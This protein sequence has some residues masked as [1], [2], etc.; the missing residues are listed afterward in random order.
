MMLSL[1]L[2]IVLLLFPAIS[3]SRP[4]IA[5]AAPQPLN[6]SIDVS[7]PHRSAYFSPAALLPA[8]T[9]AHSATALANGDIMV[10]GGYGKLFAK[11]PVATNLIRLFDHHNLSWRIAAGKLNFGR[12]EHAAIRLPDNSVL[13]VGGRGQDGNP[14]RSIELFNPSDETCTLIG[15]MAIARLRPCLNLISPAP[16]QP[17]HFQVL[18]TGNSRR[19]ELIEPDPNRPDAYTIRPTRSQSLANHTDHTTVTLKDGRVLI[20]A[21]RSNAIEIYDPADESFH[22][23][24]SRLPAAL[25]DQAAALLYDSR[26]FIAG[27]QFIYNNT[28]TNRTWLFDPLADTLT[29]GPVLKPTSQTQ[30]QPGAADLAA[31]D[32][33]EYDLTR[34]GRYILLCGGENDPGKGNSPDIVLDSAWV[35]D[36]QRGIFLDVGPMLYGHDDFAAALLPAANGLARVLIIAGFGQSDTFQANCELFSCRLNQLNN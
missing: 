18:I 23:C 10:A 14:M 12:L 35:F 2:L 17:D 24:R 6:S 33:F 3:A 4:L 26:V 5:D 36:A 29:A 1:R 27:G 30:I 8:A 31:I 9:I 11:I 34:R 21:G 20:I 25:D 32:L 13:I 28:C 19:A 22:L 7:P 15:Q 16:S